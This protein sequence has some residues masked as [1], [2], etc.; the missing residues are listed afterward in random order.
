[1]ERYRFAPGTLFVTPRCELRSDDLA[2]HHLRK[3]GQRVL[4]RIPVEV[5]DD[6]RRR[7]EQRL[8]RSAGVGAHAVPREKR[9]LISSGIAL[10]RMPPGLSGSRAAHTRFSLQSTASSP[11][12]R[13]RCWSLKLDRPHSATELSITMSSPKVQ[14]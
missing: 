13:I 12:F 2:G 5:I 14:G 10:A 9:D 6:V 4:R 11:S 3:D 7:I 1:M 8:Q